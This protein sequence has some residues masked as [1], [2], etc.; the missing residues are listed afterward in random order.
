[1]DIDPVGAAGNSHADVVRSH[2]Y[3]EDGTIN[4]PELKKGGIEDEC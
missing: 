4:H 2:C 1:M 3:K